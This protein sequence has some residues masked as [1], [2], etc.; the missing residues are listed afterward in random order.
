MP[1][2]SELI[3]E[4][5]LSFEILSD[6]GNKLGHSYGLIHTLPPELREVYLKFG[7][8]LPMYN[9]DDTWSLP[10]AARFI[11]D[12]ECII[13]YAEYDADYTVRPE[14]EHTM[15]ALKHLGEDAS[16]EEAQDS[17]GEAQ[18]AEPEA[19]EE[20]SEPEADSTKE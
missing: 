16:E 12:Q 3:K 7:I 5:K 20:P 18:D 4:K 15:S 6:P 19:V 1:Y 11:I 8:D 17:E 9:G 10:L 13:R 14:I 2:N